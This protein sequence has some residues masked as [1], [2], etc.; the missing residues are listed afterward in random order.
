MATKATKP[1]PQA[2]PSEPD[3]TAKEKKPGRPKGFSTKKNDLIK[4]VD[5]TP[6]KKIAPQA[7]VIVNIV[8]AAGKNGI[9][10]GELVKSMEGVVQTRQPQERIFAYY[11]KMLVEDGFLTVIPGEPEAA[12]E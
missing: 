8:K 5:P 11:Q 4:A 7:A 12:A 9:T 6:D 3:K 2:P 10:R 1:A